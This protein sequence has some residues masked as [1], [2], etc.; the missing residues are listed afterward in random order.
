[1]DLLFKQVIFCLTSGH[2]AARCGEGRVP[3]QPGHGTKR[4][5]E[6]SPDHPAQA[7]V[8]G[9]TPGHRG[10]RRPGSAHAQKDRLRAQSCGLGVRAV[11]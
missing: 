5:S 4:T 2:R 8:A 6:P 1:M 11:A 3:R 7:R 9:H 10:S